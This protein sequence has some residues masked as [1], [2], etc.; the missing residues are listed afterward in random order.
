MKKGGPLAL[1][2]RCALSLTRS[3]PPSPRLSP[4][5]FM[6]IKGGLREA[7]CSA[8]QPRLV[9]LVSPSPLLAGWEVWHGC[10]LPGRLLVITSMLAWLPA[11]L[12]VMAPANLSPR[13][14]P[15]FYMSVTRRFVFLPLLGFF[16]DL[17][18]T[19]VPPL[20]CRF[21]AASITFAQVVAGS[22]VRS[23]DSAG[24]TPL[25]P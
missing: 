3:S 7:W 10:L 11:C 15:S 13:I 9:L 18:P 17:R 16:P 25:S 2:V 12:F 20:L 6:S 24:K 14:F 21:A 5:C 22:G 19:V 1:C 4:P 8:K 23:L